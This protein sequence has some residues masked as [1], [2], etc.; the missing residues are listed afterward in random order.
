MFFKLFYFIINIK[1]KIVAYIKKLTLNKVV[2]RYDNCF[3]CRRRR[4][5]YIRNRYCC[6]LC[7]Y[8]GWFGWFVLFFHLFLWFSEKF[9]AD[10]VAQISYLFHAG[11]MHLNNL[12][13]KTEVNSSSRRIFMMKSYY[14][15]WVRPI[16]DIINIFDTIYRKF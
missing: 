5:L 6:C 12:R 7:F 11:F 16:I 14:K 15:L 13:A 1:I 8:C 3:G 9:L 10:G 4:R 2:Y